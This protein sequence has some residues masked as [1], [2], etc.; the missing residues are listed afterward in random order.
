MTTNRNDWKDI[1]RALEAGLT[2]EI[3]DADGR[4]RQFVAG[5][6]TSQKR[7][8]KTRTTHIGPNGGWIWVSR[9]GIGQLGAQARKRL[10]N[11]DE[12]L[13]A[14]AVRNRRFLDSD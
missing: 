3:S 13:K 2:L 8:G 1:K 10:A 11:K 5:Q 4:I 9:W 12:I 14:A 7:G 6:I